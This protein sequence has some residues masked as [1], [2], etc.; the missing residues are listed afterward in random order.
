M[1][2]D[3]EKICRQ[4]GITRQPKISGKTFA[5]PGGWLKFVHIR[6]PH[7]LRPWRTCSHRSKCATN[8]TL[9]F[10]AI[11]AGSLDWSSSSSSFEDFLQWMSFGRFFFGV[12]TFT[13]ES[14]EMG[15]SRE[16]ERPGQT[17]RSCCEGF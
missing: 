8:R 6:S 17:L 12:A 14:L 11:E 9:S 16:L 5:R 4:S 13:V 7:I 2:K 10:E 3:L 15:T 1:H